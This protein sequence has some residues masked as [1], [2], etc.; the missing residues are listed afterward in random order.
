MVG[1]GLQLGKRSSRSCGED[2]NGKVSFHSIRENAVNVLLLGWSDVWD[3]LHSIGGLLCISFR[4][5]LDFTATL[6]PEPQ[7]SQGVVSFV[8]EIFVFL[9]SSLRRPTSIKWMNQQQQYS[10]LLW[11][12][13]ICSKKT[14]TRIAVKFIL[15]YSLMFSWRES[16][17][18]N[19]P[20]WWTQWDHQTRLMLRFTSCGPG[21]ARSLWIFKGFHQ[22]IFQA[23]LSYM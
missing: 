10:Q 2:S 21:I 18:T 22:N 15:L 3:L 20:L 9:C 14:C 5:S 8:C 17:W 11:H 7:G 4:F 1:S 23:V 13:F 16:W 12:E 6:E 19:E